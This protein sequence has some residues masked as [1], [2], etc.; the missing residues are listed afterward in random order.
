[1]AVI[2]E[3]V[4][5]RPQGHH[6]L[7]PV[8]VDMSEQRI[9]IV[10]RNG[11]GKS[12]FARLL[13][14]LVA[15]DAGKVTIAGVDVAKNR[16]EAVS[17]VGIIFQNPDHQIIF[18]TVGEEMAFGLKQMGMSQD[19]AARKVMQVLADHHCADWADR[20]THALSQGQ[21]HLVC[22]MSVLAMGPKTIVLDEPYAGL[23]IPTSMQLHRW[24]DQ[25]TLQIILITHDPKVLTGFDRVLW[26]EGGMIAGD[27]KAHPVLKNFT[28]EMKRLGG[29][30]ASTDTSA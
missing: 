18:P 30:D 3:N 19:D 5:Y 10:G 25:L 21:R 9:G 2:F 17:T 8:S 7:G 16:K 28:H 13:T 1:M 6:V 4:E 14:G 12:S 29:G 24:L 27:G 20:N 26:F 23:D 22:L 11:S 15:P